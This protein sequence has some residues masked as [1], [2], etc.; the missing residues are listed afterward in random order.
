M[1]NRVI[2]DM[3]TCFVVIKVTQ[4]IIF[5]RIISY[6]IMLSEKNKK[7]VYNIKSYS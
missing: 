2:T 6:G 4:K 5:I 3:M 7:Y 1:L